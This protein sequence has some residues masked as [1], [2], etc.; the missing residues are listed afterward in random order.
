V[1]KDITREVFRRRFGGGNTGALSASSL[2]VFRLTQ[3]ESYP[4]LVI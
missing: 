4:C 3:W 2:P 1:A